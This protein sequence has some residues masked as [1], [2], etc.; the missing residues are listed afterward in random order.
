VPQQLLS[1]EDVA[2]KCGLSRKAIYRAIERGEL[3][4]TRIC[5]RIRIRPE[6]VD[7]WI[8]ANLVPPR[9]ADVRVPRAAALPARQGLRRLLAEP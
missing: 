8:E 3:T 9:V 4:A 2:A 7:E 6:D 1:P 5:S